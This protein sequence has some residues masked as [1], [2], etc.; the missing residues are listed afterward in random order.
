MCLF[1][2]RPVCQE[3]GNRLCR[4]HYLAARQHHSHNREIL[5]L[6]AKYRMH[7]NRMIKW[8]KEIDKQYKQVNH[9][10]EILQFFQDFE[11]RMVHDVHYNELFNEM[12]NMV[13]RLM[14]AQ[15]EMEVYRQKL[16]ND[17]TN[18]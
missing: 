3:S 10:R 16:F 14:R 17:F 1:C 8:Q 15:R 7:M 6:L 18:F 12:D 4:V 13:A 5:P 2:S 9:R 11:S